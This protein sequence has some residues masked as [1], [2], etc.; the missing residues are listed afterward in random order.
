MIEIQINN[1]WYSL[2][3][4]DSYEEI[5]ELG[6]IQALDGL[7]DGIDL[8]SDFDALK[9]FDGMTN[10]NQKIVMAYAEVTDNFNPEEALEAYVGSY[11]TTADFAQ[12]VCE[13]VAG[14]ALEALPSYLRDCIKWSDVWDYYLRHDYFAYNGH[15]FRNL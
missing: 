3:A 6:E 13:D 11:N 1:E 2:S 15:Y 10:L 7:P 12:S 9:T 8:E 4:F 5:E 14:E